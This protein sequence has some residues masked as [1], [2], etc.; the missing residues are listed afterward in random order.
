MST[1]TESPPTPLQLAEKDRPAREL[2]VSYVF[3]PVARPLVQVLLALRIPPLAVLVA[4]LAI[5]LGAGLLLAL[6]GALPA[7]ALLQLRTLLDNADGTLAR[8]RARVT[9]AGRYLDTEADL[10]VNAALFA[11]LAHETGRPWL[12]LASFCALTLVLGVGFNLAELQREALGR[13][14]APPAPSGG[15]LE[16]A[17]AAVYG[18]VF[19]PQDRALRTLSARRLR[20]VLADEPDAERRLRATRAYH[21]RTM[22]AYL[23]NTGL[24]TQLAALGAC[25]VAG[26]PEVYLWLALACLVPLPFLQLRR[27]RVARRALR[28]AA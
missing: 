6:G 21:D 19:A 3:A 23:A 7:A 28:G 14:H 13:A 16:R 5:G 26:A 22:L 9:L 27:E 25:L 2:V 10:V 4:H 1:S 11:A 15:A 20:R 17:L 8:A 18:V 24:S 12:S